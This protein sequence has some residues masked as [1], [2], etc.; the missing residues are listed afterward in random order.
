MFLNDDAPFFISEFLKE[1]GSEFLWLEKWY[2]WSTK[3]GFR[4]PEVYDSYKTIY[5]YPVDRAR[6][7]RLNHIVTPNPFA[8]AVLFESMMCEVIDTPTMVKIIMKSNGPN[9][10]VNDRFFIF[11]VIEIMTSDVRSN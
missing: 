9:T 5:D 3:E 10:F 4:E 1:N 6:R 7:F 8:K 2:D 11:E